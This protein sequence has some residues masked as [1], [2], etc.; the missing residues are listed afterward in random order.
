[1]SGTFRF[2]FNCFVLNPVVVL[3][4]VSTF[5]PIL[6]CLPPVGSLRLIGLLPFPTLLPPL[7][8]SLSRLS[9]P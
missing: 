3:N 2:V 5:V 9:S 8:A 7:G 1:M 4:D 6:N